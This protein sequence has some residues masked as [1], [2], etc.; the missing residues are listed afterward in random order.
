VD[1]AAS[2]LRRSLRPVTWIVLEE[3]ALAAVEIDGALIAPTSTRLIAEHL[4]IDPGSAA[5]ALRTLRRRGLVDLAQRV[6]PNGRFGLAVYS[7][8]LPAGLAVVSSP[9]VDL[10]HAE[11]PHAVD[12]HTP[13]DRS[14]GTPRPRPPRG[15]RRVDQGTL[16]L[17]LGIR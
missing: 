4:G 7:V 5:T 3:L 10:P 16:D 12:G 9:C 13:D 1:G 14:T 6:E 17:G 8:H 11:R 15:S 2:D